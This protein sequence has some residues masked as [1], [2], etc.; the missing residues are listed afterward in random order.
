MQ[1]GSSQNTLIGWSIAPAVISGSNNTGIGAGSFPLLTGGADNV[2]VG[3]NA[4]LSLTTGSSNTAIGD[5]SGL[6]V[7]TGSNNVFV[8]AGASLSGGS[9]SN[10]IAIGVGAVAWDSC[11]SIGYQAGNNAYNGD[12]STF[13]GY[14]SGLNM[15]SGNA[16][17]LIGYQTGTTLGVGSSNVF[18]GDRA[19]VAA[20]DGSNNVFI[21]SIAGFAT[22]V[23]VN[24]V[25]VGAS[26]GQSMAGANDNYNVLIGSSAGVLM[27]GASGG[28]G[29]NTAIGTTALS[30]M[31][32]G[33]R[34]VGI[35]S[36]CGLSN[37]TSNWS[38]LIG[39]LADVHADPANNALVISSSTNG[40]KAS[41]TSIVIVTQ[42]VDSAVSNDF[43]IESGVVGL[44]RALG[45]GGNDGGVLRITDGGNGTGAG[46]LELAG[47]P[48]AFEPPTAPAN[49]GRI[50][51]N[52][53]TN[54]FMFSSNTG[55]Y[56]AL[57]LP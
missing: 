55:A 37:V 24:N 19:G 57:T 9:S 29:E 16:N 41:D 8:G 1:V 25:C 31:T 17:T 21:G 34:N 42:T 18:I 13:I 33:R 51:Y 47:I 6:T 36:A 22:T 32:T 43:I 20:T 50:Y 10:A 54:L 28:D 44:R 35:G 30:A 4:F 53:D 39:Y 23:G 38:V 12:R 26:A 3:S 45:T 14:Q 52:S 48:T 15:N 56:V 46:A 49:C 2:I 27:N 11:I 5:A 7:D 40:A